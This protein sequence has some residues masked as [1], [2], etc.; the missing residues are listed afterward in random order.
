MSDFTYVPDFV[1]E[2]TAEYKTLISEFE[3]GVEQRRRKWANPRRKWTLR[4]HSRSK[5]E[6][7]AVLDFFKAKY[8]AFLSF[9]WTNP[10]DAAEYTVRYQEDSFKSSLK[11]YDV[12]DF[13]FAFIEVK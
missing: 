13:E 2:E 5:S 12:Y 1:L 6:M 7:S 3:S 8:G 11:A 4:F 10:N 9:T